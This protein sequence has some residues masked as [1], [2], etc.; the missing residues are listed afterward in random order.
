VAQTIVVGTDGSQ[1]ADR[2]LEEAIDIAQRDGARLHLVTAFP[3]PAVIRERVTSG[4][5]SVQVN[6]SE[7]ADSVLTR[8]AERAG[9]KGVPVETYASESDPAEAILEVAKAQDADLIVVGSRGLS[10]I[11]RFLLG[12]VSSK[13][14]EH[15]ACSVM[16]VRG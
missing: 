16:I 1:A 6:L 14:S 7:I 12:S 5:T 3:D 13:V 15:A 11:Q 8:A 4:A 2:A 9:E 10:G